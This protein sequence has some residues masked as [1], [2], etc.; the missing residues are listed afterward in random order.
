MAACSGKSDPYATIR[1]GSEIIGRTATA[2]DLPR[3]RVVRGYQGV[4]H[5][6]MKLL[7]S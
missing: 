1:F 6:V 2:E 3:P 7:R 5:W 4:Y